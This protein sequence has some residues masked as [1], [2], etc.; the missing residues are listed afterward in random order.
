[1]LHASTQADWRIAEWIAPDRKGGL[2][3]AL[4]TLR[5]DRQWLFHGTRYP[6][7]ILAGNAL[8][9]PKLPRL[10]G[11][12]TEPEMGYECVSLTR[13]PDV[14]SYWATLERDD[15]ERLG[16]VLVF[17]RSVLR[18]RYKLECCHDPV[19]SEIA[20]GRHD[21]CEE[22]VWQDIK[23]LRSYLAGVVWECAVCGV[24]EA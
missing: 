1:M 20:F 22:Q 17:D 3:Y 13:S 18:T 14:A 11:Q 24:A 10:P 8:R 15:D 7:A 6:E 4:R 5:R 9:C 16:A 19:W 21:E 2:A 12:H 23:P